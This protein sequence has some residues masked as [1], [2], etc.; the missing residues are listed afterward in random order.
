M[1]MRVKAGYRWEQWC[2]GELFKAR[3]PSPSANVP[4]KT[5]WL[6]CYNTVDIA[7][8]DFAIWIGYNR[9]LSDQEM[10]EVFG[11]LKSIAPYADDNTRTQLITFGDSITEHVD[12]IG[13]SGEAYYWPTLVSN[14]LGIPLSN[15]GLG[16]THFV[17]VNSNKST[18]NS[19]GY[20]RYFKDIALFAPL[21][22]AINYGMNDLRTGTLYANA[23]SMRQQMLDMLRDLTKMGI[24]RGN[25]VVTTIPN[26][27]DASYD[28]GKKGTRPK[29]EALNQ[30]IKDACRIAGVKVADIY[31]AMSPTE[32]LWAADGFH[33]NDAGHAVMADV[34][35][36]A[37]QDLTPAP[38]P[39]IILPELPESRLVD[40]DVLN[41]DNLLVADAGTRIT[42]LKPMAGTTVE[43]NLGGRLNAQ[44]P[45]LEWYDYD[46]INPNIV[47]LGTAA[48]GN[49]AGHGA[50]I[51]RFDGVD[52]ILTGNYP[53][54]SNEWTWFFVFYG[55]TLSSGFRVQT[56]SSYAIHAWIDNQDGDGLKS[57]ISSDGG[58]D[59]ALTVKT[60]FEANT[61]NHL[62]MRYKASDSWEQWRNGKVLH[63]RPASSLGEVPLATLWL[64]AYQPALDK[65]VA[66]PAAGGFTRWIA[67]NRKL[68]DGEMTTVFAA[69][70]YLYPLGN[71]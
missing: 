59:A 70:K 36:T 50:A 51:A 37:L 1:A 18:P 44:A 49:T 35:A 16:G 65:A 4:A 39:S 54:Q 13:T 24:E 48:A 14:Q 25:I 58:T 64:G 53:A 67:W 71:S 22:V 15:Q 52:K 45:Y 38:E 46:F 10:G 57:A 2:N 32:P 43:V 17:G 5:L 3:Y 63:S 42:A 66:A 20:R 9:Y 19:T 6:G 61:W 7:V 41:L 11:H 28:N 23:S 12:W 8:G 21:K 55:P 56:G 27:T 69:L 68:S 33:P 34:V 30:A 47:P 40:L 29:H 26:V 62:A 31:T 60:G